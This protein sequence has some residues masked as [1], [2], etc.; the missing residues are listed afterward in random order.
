MIY[1]ISER[2]V[3]VLPDCSGKSELDYLFH[4]QKNGS[5]NSRTLWIF[6][7]RCSCKRRYRK[8]LSILILFSF[9]SGVNARLSTDTVFIGR[10]SSEQYE[11]IAEVT[12][13]DFVPS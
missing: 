9:R 6:K 7:P 13:T 11:N 4:G 8:R 5:S 1:G 10:P 12:M 2:T 3:S